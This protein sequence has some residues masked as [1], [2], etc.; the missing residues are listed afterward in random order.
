MS[1]LTRRQAFGTMALGATALTGAAVASAIAS[2]GGAFTDVVP[3]PSG[4][5]SL[6]SGSAGAVRR[7]ARH[8]EDR[9][10]LP[11]MMAS[12][13]HCRSW[14]SSVLIQLQDGRQGLVQLN[15]QAFAIASAAQASGRSI[16]IRVWG[17][18]DQ[19]HEGVGRFE[20]ALVAFDLDDLPPKPGDS[21]LH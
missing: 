13:A 19:L 4:S 8:V 14:D 20:G 15:A 18:N 21:S 5:R 6:R 3:I 1:K 12:V 2:T 9:P 11:D 10:S 16:A 17:H 7:A